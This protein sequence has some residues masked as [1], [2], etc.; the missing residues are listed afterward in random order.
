MKVLAV[1]DPHGSMKKIGKIP[2]KL[3][4][5][6]D[7]ILITGDLG[8]ADLARKVAFERI[9]REKEGLPELEENF[10]ET[11]KIYEEV[12]NST[13]KILKHFSKYT[14]TYTIQGNVR[15]FSSKDVKNYK[16]KYNIKCKS[17]LDIINKIKKVSLVKN[18]VRIINGLRVGFLEYFT[19][20][21]WVKEFKPEDYR[22]S[23]KSARKETDKA[24]RVL[25]RFGEKID[26]LVCH[27]PPF[28]VLDKV[29]KPA[30]KHWRGKR[31]GSKAILSYIKK[32]QPKYVLCGHIHEGEGKKKIG[33]SKVYNLGVAGYKSIEINL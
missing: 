25:K 20:V 19:D 13:L 18:R 31:A 21:S 10:K 16:K 28:G 8:K 23:M 17:T 1:G 27:Q 14:N 4:K 11:E 15:I 26:I 12:H 24:K 2:L 22:D 3:K 29:G 7:V 30:P 5:D 33:K 32:Y 6:A 9:R